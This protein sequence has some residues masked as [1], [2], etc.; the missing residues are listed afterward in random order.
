MKKL[1]ISGTCAFAA[2]LPVR[3]V[4]SGDLSFLGEDKKKFGTFFREAS[5]F[6]SATHIHVSCATPRKIHALDE[7]TR[8]DFLLHESAVGYAIFKVVHQQDAVGLHLK[9]V[10]KAGQDL[11]KFGKMVQLVNFAPW[12]YCQLVSTNMLYTSS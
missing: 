10:Q 4:L 8:I 1:E 3:Y 9:E 6:L 7:M 5:I 12:R 2:L 11:S